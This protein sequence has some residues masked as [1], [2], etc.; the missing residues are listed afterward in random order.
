LTARKS[1]ALPS[2][3]NCPRNPECYLVDL[4]LVVVDLRAVMEDPRL[5]TPEED[6]LRREAEVDGL[7]QL[8]ADKG[9][10][11]AQRT[12]KTVD[13]VVAA[14]PPHPPLANRLT[15]LLASSFVISIRP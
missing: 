4:L 13:D 14:D 8:H 11:R 15:H 2:S 9:L 5:A 12:G 1:T 10:D 3:H 6:A 7:L